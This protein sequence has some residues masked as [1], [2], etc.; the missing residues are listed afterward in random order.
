LVYLLPF[1]FFLSTFIYCFVFLYFFPLFIFIYFFKKISF[2]LTLHLFYL[3]IYHFTLAYL[4]PFFLFLSSF[5][6]L[7]SCFTP[8][9]IY[10][11][12][13]LSFCFTRGLFITTLF[14]LNFIHSLFCDIFAEIIVIINYH[15]FFFFTLHLAYLSLFYTCPDTNFMITW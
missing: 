1:L 14:V 4:S 12:K 7:F 9:F 8:F 3:P 11:K 5:I 6:Y 15:P 13:I 2:F 10:K